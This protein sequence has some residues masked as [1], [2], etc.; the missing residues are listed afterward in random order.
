MLFTLLSSSMAA[1]QTTPQYGNIDELLEQLND[2]S[3]P[4]I[5][6]QDLSKNFTEYQILDTRKK[7]EYEVSHLPGAIWV[8]Q[9]YR[10]SRI[11]M[12]DATTPIVVYCTVGVRS[13]DY[14]ERLLKAGFTQVYNLYGSIFSWKDAGYN[15]VDGNNLPTDAVHIFSHEWGKYLKTGKKVF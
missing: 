2:D 7:S 9:S 11:K 14:G 10:R 4:Y 15:L 5:H 1:Q 12:L 13:E 8:G 3:V 6:V